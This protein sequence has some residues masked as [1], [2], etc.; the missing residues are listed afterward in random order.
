MSAFRGKADITICGMSAFEVAVGGKADMGGAVRL[1][2]T[3]W[4]G[5]RIWLNSYPWLRGISP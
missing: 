5:L 1:G 2:P 3:F 4:K